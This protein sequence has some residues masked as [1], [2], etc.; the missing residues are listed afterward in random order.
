M[1][2][3]REKGDFLIEDITLATHSVRRWMKSGLFE[4]ARASGKRTSMFSIP[5]S[6]AWLRTASLKEPTFLASLT[7]EETSLWDRDLEVLECSRDSPKEPEL[8][9]SKT[10]RVISNASLCEINGVPS[11]D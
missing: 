1:V 3:I 5:Y 11:E 2:L 9:I 6:S 8:A 4:M 7:I 10:L